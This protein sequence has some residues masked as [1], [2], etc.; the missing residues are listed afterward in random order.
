[1]FDFT[2][3][4]QPVIQFMTLPPSPGFEE[5]VSTF[6]DEVRDALDGTATRVRSRV[7]F[8]QF[9]TSGNLRDD[10]H[11]QWAVFNSCST[12]WF[13]LKCGEIFDLRPNFFMTRR[14]S[15]FRCCAVSRKEIEASSCRHSLAP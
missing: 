11:V 8:R 9:P 14:F 15:A 13:G 10:S 7:H 1:M 5:L 12:E 4:L 6:A 3:S 2:L